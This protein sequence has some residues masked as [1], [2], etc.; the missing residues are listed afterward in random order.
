LGKGFSILY[1]WL[2]LNTL[3]KTMFETIHP[4]NRIGLVQEIFTHT[5]SSHYQTGIF[6]SLLDDFHDPVFRQ[7]PLDMAVLFQRDGQVILVQV[8]GRGQ[9]L[10]A[11]L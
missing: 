10:S 6:V 11:T 8:S 2:G 3:L 7:D 1:P 5:P 9:G 4:G